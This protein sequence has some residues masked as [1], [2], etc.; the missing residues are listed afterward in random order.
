MKELAIGTEALQP[1]SSTVQGCY[2]S[3]SKAWLC[4]A[5]CAE[6]IQRFMTTG[7]HVDQIIICVQQSQQSW[8]ADFPVFTKHTCGSRF[9]SIRGVL[10]V[11]FGEGVAGKARQPVVHTRKEPQ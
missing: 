9:T 5:A 3:M 10:L 8:P 1:E 4:T 2:P 11:S 7:D 6:M